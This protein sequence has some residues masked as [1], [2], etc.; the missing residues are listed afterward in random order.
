MDIV[1]GYVSALEYWRTV[2]ERFLRTSRQRRIATRRARAVL[3]SNEKPRLQAGNR[4]PAG[5]KLPLN[6]V[7][8][9][10]SAR[11]E[12][13][14][15]V[16][17]TW[18]QPIADTSFAD[19]GAGFLVSSPEFCFLQMAGRYSLARLILLGFEL[20][21][22]FALDETGPARQRVAPLTTADKLRAFVE[23]AFGAYGRKKALVALR[24]VKNGSASPMEAVLAM[25]LCLPYK[26]GGYGLEWPRLNYRVDVLPS[27]RKLADRGYCKAD[28]CWPRADLCV[29][30]DSELHHADAERRESDA[31]RRSTLIA[32]GYTV[33]T[34]TP[35][36]IMDGGACN[37]LAHQVAKLTGKR[38]RYVDP[39]FTHAHLALRSELF[40]AVDMF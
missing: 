8:A 29:E 25:L 17:H 9:D 1:I 24:Y 6:V 38:L 27:M 21:G 37:R 32:L 18:S 28:L 10:E 40:E 20:C 4:R 35:G 33:I 12:T 2:G 30:Y 3:A 23:G 11:T 16:T 13:A 31:R 5:C 14:G 22:T 39:G 19:A 26:M 34:V 36:Q 15:V 7:V